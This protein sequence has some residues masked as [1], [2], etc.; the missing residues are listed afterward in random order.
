MHLVAC[1]R[2]R[3]LRVANDDDDVRTV[4]GDGQ[5]NYEEFVRMML[6]K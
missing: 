5:I 2:A 6:S 4:D 3:G 1:T